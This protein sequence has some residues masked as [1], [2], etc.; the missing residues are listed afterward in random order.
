MATTTSFEAKAMSQLSILPC[1]SESNRYW[2]FEDPVDTIHRARHRPDVDAVLLFVNKR[3][4][5][6]PENKTIFLTN[7][8]RC[9][10]PWK[11]HWFTFDKK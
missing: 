6:S 5:A 8:S 3:T 9:G 11:A 7:K 2:Q 10:A 4:A 1:S